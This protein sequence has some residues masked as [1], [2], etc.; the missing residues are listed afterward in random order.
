MVRERERERERGI[1]TY[2]ERG[3]EGGNFAER[4]RMKY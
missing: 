3:I 4:K 1:E 2:R